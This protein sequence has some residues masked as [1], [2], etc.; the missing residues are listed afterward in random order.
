[1]YIEKMDGEGY[2]FL[3]GLTCDEHGSKAVFVLRTYGSGFIV[4][5]CQECVDD[6][7]KEMM[8]HASPEVL[9]ANM[10]G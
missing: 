7:Y 9:D 8:E 2:T 10:K 5:M 6:L 1:M 3:D 4:P